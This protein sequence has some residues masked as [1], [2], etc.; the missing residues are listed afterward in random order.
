MK[1]L[2]SAWH[3]AAECVWCEKEKET[4]SVEFG[5]GFLTNS[6]ICW[7]CLQKAIRVRARNGSKPNNV[8]LPKVANQA[9]REAS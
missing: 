9:S 2:I 8:R 1:T 4:V 6:Q 5:D 7:R 3:E